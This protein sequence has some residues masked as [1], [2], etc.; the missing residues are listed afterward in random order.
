MTARSIIIRSAVAVGATLLLCAQAPAAPTPDDYNAMCV[1]V[2]KDRADLVPQC[3]AEQ[4]MAHHFTLSWL[5]QA[6][7]LAEDGSID[8][9]RILDAQAEASGL[10]DSPGAAAAFCLE[11]G[12]NWIA[13]SQCITTLDSNSL[14]SFG[15]QAGAIGEP[16]MDGG[17]AASAAPSGN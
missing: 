8:P 12:D 5:D 7:F 2:L 9:L 10:P 6:G 16:F 17:H 1:R 11:N 4:E 14:F 15:N 3:R 13:I